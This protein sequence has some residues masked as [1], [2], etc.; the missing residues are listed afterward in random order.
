M[1]PETPLPEERSQ[2]P[3]GCAGCN[4][5]VIEHG[6]PTPLCRDCRDNFIK[7][8]IPRVIKLFGAVLG[9]ILLYAMSGVPKNL[10]TG[11]HYERGKEAIEKEN[12]FTAQRELTTVIDKAPSFLEAKEYLAIASFL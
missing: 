12:Y 8:P 5:P 2:E 9:I 4:H 6:Y 1:D 11:I 10:A 3:K 7:F